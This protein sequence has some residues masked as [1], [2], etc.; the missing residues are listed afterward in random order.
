M[1]AFIALLPHLKFGLN[2]LLSAS[3]ISSKPLLPQCVVKHESWNQLLVSQTGYFSYILTKTTPDNTLNAEINVRVKISLVSKTLKRF[4]K[5]ERSITL[6]TKFLRSDLLRNTLHKKIFK[7]TIWCI[8]KECIVVLSTNTAM[9]QRFKLSTDFLCSQS[10]PFSTCSPQQYQ[11]AL[12]L[13][14]CPF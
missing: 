1:S 8:L 6:L 11:S 7:W 12:L 2:Q 9:K 3:D 5:T 10:L 4:A 13:Y 14:F